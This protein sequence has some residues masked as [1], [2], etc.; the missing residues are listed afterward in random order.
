D[1]RIF[2]SIQ[3]PRRGSEPQRICQAEILRDFTR[4][5]LAVDPRANVILLGDM[6]EHEFR[7]PSRILEEELVALMLRVP[8][9]RRYTYNFEGNSQVLDHIFAS[10]ALVEQSRPEIDVVHVNTD[11]PARSAASD[12]DPVIARFHFD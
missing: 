3:P 4:S 5:L 7:A 12:H 11:F 6:N 2:G 10:K 8:G 1:D 9:S